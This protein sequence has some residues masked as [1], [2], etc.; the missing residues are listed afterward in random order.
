MASTIRTILDIITEATGNPSEIEFAVDLTKDN[1][2]NASFYL[3][4]IKPLSG[5]SYGY[6]I[7]P[8]SIDNENLILLSEKSMGNGVIDNITDIIYI[9]PESF[10]KLRT[11]E[12]AEEIEL[13]NDIMIKE[14]RNYILIGPGRWGS[15]DIF[16]GIPV[17]WSAISN[18]K[19]I[20]EVGLPG[21][22]LDASL[23]SHFFHNVT[24]M[25]IG[26]FAVNSDTDSGEINWN[27][28]NEQHIIKK[29]KYI[30]HIR[31]ERPLLVRMD[32]KKGLAVITYNNKQFEENR[33]Q[34]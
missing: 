16:L 32:G 14:N 9:G 2:G 34:D 13:F 10:D 22:N 5:N 11:V 20:V 21:Y 8:E 27:I 3:L 1:E 12:I 4:Q 28:L 25:R 18:A 15:M 7:N 23:G 24:S 31:F 26:Y 19:V 17:T 6:N 29:G 33:Q 30:K